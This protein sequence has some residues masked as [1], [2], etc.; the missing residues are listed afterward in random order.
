M[1]EQN[2][3]ISINKY[4]NSLNSQNPSAFFFV[5]IFCFESLGWS[6]NRKYAL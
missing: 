1:L 4:K 2:W 5:K 6:I 3:N